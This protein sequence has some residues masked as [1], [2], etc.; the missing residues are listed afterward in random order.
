MDSMNAEV[1]L[2]EVA[3]IS[4][5]YDLLYQ[6]TGGY[7]NIF[8]IAD[9]SNKEVAVCRVLCE[10]LSP[11]G[12]HYQGNIYLK[13]FVRD[14]LDENNEMNISDAELGND[15]VYVEREKRIGGD[16]RIDL[17]ISTS[18]H[19]IPIEVKIW[20]KDLD[21]Q[22]KDYFKEAIGSKLYYLTPFGNNPSKESMAG[23][24]D[25][26]VKTI[27]FEHDI[28]NWLEKCLTLKETIKLA[29]IREILQQFASA[30]RRFTN[31]M[32]DDKGMEI[33]NMIGASKEN[34]ES[35]KEI[36]EVFP[37]VK[38]EMMKRVF[39]EI[40]AHINGRL[41]KPKNELSGMA[42]DV[43]SYY[44]GSKFANLL[45][46]IP[47]IS[48]EEKKYGL[49]FEVEHCLYFGLLDVE[50][51][52]GGVYVAREKIDTPGAGTGQKI[53]NPLDEK[54]LS[55]DKW[56]YWWNYM[57]NNGTKI[58]FRGCNDAYMQLFDEKQHGELM[59]KIFKRIDE[60]LDG[61]GVR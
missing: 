61:I 56:W 57:P 15:D 55:E 45:F 5:K 21:T 47:S 50:L 1:M 13:L 14:V 33:K 26:N 11:K 36:V 2:R 52:E 17:F 51:N 19:K 30:I 34:F 43:D 8:E 23:L 6:K 46:L 54:I 24:D 60:F 4:R 20:A 7:F 31:Q 12:C 59:G 35:A 38:A 28:L 48:P 49:L 42:N 37:S 16:R 10:L 39:E 53:P 44:K 9:I 58:D 32:E 18:K 27:S 41:E 40:D 22:C 29:P 3:A 25:N